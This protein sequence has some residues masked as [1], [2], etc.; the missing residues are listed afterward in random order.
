MS[1]ASPINISAHQL[2]RPDFVTL[3]E[4]SLAES[5][6]APSLLELEITESS[7]ELARQVASP[8]PARPGPDSRPTAGCGAQ[9][10]VALPQV[11][12][13]VAA[14]VVGAEHRLEGGGDQA[15][16]LVAQEDVPGQGRAL[17][18]QFVQQFLVE[19]GVSEKQAGVFAQQ[20]VRFEA[21]ERREVGPA[22]GDSG[23]GV[24][25]NGRVRQILLAR[26]FSRGGNSFLLQ[27]EC[28]CGCRWQTM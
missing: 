20:L 23:P 4:T 19:I 8:A 2:R 13:Q 26:A 15:S 9:H 18:R 21:E 27:P 14:A 24:D 11:Q 28:R 25:R 5:G 17:P 6:L 1:K 12:D 3:V 7:L 10:Q 22:T 16:V